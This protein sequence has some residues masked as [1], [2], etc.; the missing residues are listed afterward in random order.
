[1]VQLPRPGSPGLFPRVSGGRGSLAVPS[2]DESF[3]VDERVHPTL[4][5]GSRIAAEVVLVDGKTA[6]AVNN[7][8]VG[9]MTVQGAVAVPGAPHD[10]GADGW[11]RPDRKRVGS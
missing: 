8:D 2:V 10:D 7:R 4:V 11:S 5:G 9:D 6:G 1:M 3:N